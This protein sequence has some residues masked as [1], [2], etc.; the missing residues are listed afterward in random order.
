MRECVCL[1]VS[2]SLDCKTEERERERR[3][4]DARHRQGFTHRK[5]SK[6]EEEG[7]EKKRNDIVPYGEVKKDPSR[8]GPLDF[9]FSSLF[10][11]T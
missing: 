5:E 8:C 2:R 7:K 4:M 1:S 10:L 11:L 9:L 3:W 6:R